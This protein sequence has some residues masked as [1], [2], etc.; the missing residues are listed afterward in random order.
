MCSSCLS[1][2][3]FCWRINFIVGTTSTRSKFSEIAHVVGDVCFDLF[4]LHYGIMWPSDGNITSISW[5]VGSFACSA[6]E[7]E[8]ESRIWIIV[9]LGGSEDWLFVFSFERA[10]VCLYSTTFSC[11]CSSPEKQIST[12]QS[13]FHLSSVASFIVIFFFLD[14]VQFISL[15]VVTND[16]GAFL[17]SIRHAML[18]TLSPADFDCRLF[19]LEIFLHSESS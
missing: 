9:N 10:F 15:M 19:W 17:R 1:K 11:I 3:R 13:D 6:F 7:F 8:F 14:F 4:S 5:G 18:I 16:Q 2:A 12:E